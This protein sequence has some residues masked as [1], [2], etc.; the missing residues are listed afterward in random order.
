MAELLDWRLWGIVILCGLAT[1]IW[2]AL[3]VVVGGRVS[4][5]SEAFK[6]FS[7][8]AYAMVAGLI[9][10]MV[11]LPEGVLAEAP[12]AYRLVGIAVAVAVFFALRRNLAAGV[13]AGVAAFALLIVFAG[14][15]V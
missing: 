15:P 7:C 8:I 1:Y 12:L 6:L 4:P 13:F 9:S 2:R 11:M 10:R 5:E 3:A 14:T